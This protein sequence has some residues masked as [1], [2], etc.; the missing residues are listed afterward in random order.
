MAS[1]TSILIAHRLSTILAADEILVVKD[2]EIV[3]RG[4]HKEL[5]NA[6]GVYADLYETQFKGAMKGTEDIIRE[7]EESI[8]AEAYPAPGAR[9]PRLP[10][11]S[12]QERRE[13]I[14]ESRAYRQEVMDEI[15]EEIEE[16]RGNFLWPF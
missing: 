1:H 6:G 13:R 12:R 7:P 14:D 4:T 15:A 5:V 16:K 2:G 9:G 10:G 8:G 11:E 3:E